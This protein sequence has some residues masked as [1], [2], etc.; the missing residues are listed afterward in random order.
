[1][2]SIDAKVAAYR[3]GLI[4]GK[5]PPEKA[6]L[7]R[8]VVGYRNSLVR[9]AIAARR[10]SARPEPSTTPITDAMPPDPAAV[11]RAARL[12]KVAVQLQAVQ[13]RIA[14]A[15]MTR[16]RR[17][18]TLA[19]LHMDGGNLSAVHSAALELAHMTRVATL[20]LEAA[21]PVS[22]FP[23]P[24]LSSLPPPS[25]EEPYLDVEVGP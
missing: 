8:M 17:L 12:E 22:T 14:T 7:E 6:V 13:L 24:R 18:I 20:G 5:N 25:A 21:H 11:R 1:M 23:P 19:R 4:H 2:E 15:D 10:P 3:N 16:M 9:D